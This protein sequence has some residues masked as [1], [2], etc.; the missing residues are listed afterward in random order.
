M[1]LSHFWPPRQQQIT[2][3][4]RLLAMHRRILQAYLVERDQWP[5]SD[6]PLVLRSAIRHTR[7]QILTSKG[8][9]RGWNIPVG[10]EPTD[11]DG[12]DQFAEQVA[13]QRTLLQVHRTQ[14]AILEQQ[15]DNYPVEQVPAHVLQTISER[16]LAIEQITTLLRGWNVPDDSPIPPSDIFTQHA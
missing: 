6:V 16:E 3:H 10:D 14:L 7:N 8:M 5:Q 1:R 15:R 12:D 9:L 13:H 11:N 2:Y 4:Q